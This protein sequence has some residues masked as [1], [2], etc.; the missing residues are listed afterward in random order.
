MKDIGLLT[1][2]AKN[3]KIVTASL[4]TTRNQNAQNV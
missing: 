1:P 4:A 3:A 2:L